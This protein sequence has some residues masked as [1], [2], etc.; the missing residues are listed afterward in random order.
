MQWLQELYELLTRPKAVNSAI[1]TY[2]YIATLRQTG[3]LRGKCERAEVHSWSCIM[4]RLPAW[5]YSGVKY[6]SASAEAGR[7]QTNTVSVS[8]APPGCV[9]IELEPCTMS[10][11]ERIT[12]GKCDKRSPGHLELQEAARTVQHKQPG[13]FCKQNDITVNTDTWVSW[14]IGQKGKWDCKNAEQIITFCV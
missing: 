9:F 14:E 12:G 10:S 8:S 6:H 1:N 13:D 4:L 3:Q 11:Q 5:D 2:K 7:K